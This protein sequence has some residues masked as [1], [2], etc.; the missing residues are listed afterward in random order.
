MPTKIPSFRL[1]KPSGL[2]VAT[3]N[4]RDVYFGAFDSA[5][6][7]EKYERALL[8]W[9]SNSHRLPQDVHLNEMTVA[10]FLAAYLRHA[11]IGRT[12]E[13]LPQVKLVQVYGLSETGFLTGLQDHEHTP[14]R[15]TSCGRPCPGVDL[16]VVNDSGTPLPVGQHGEMIARGANVIRGYWNNQQETEEA[17]RHGFFGTGDIGYQDA[18]GFFYIVDR[19]K[20][21]IV[22]GGE[23]VYSGEV[24]AVLYEHPSIREAAVIGIPDPK[25]GELV[26][27]CVVL[28][29]GMMA[30]AEELMSYC[31]QSL[32]NYKVPRRVEFMTSALPKNGSGKVMKRTLREQVSTHDNERASA[33]G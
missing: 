4:G 28:K 27:A 15:L 16:Q 26:T 32:A 19:A 25:W 8:E 22:T 7:G 6:S 3:F 21:M 2:A 31:R 14:D 23:N 30:T 17:F 5:E 1:H 24:E 10:E 20:D 12:R 29:P 9:L 13:V 18:A 33:L 11:L